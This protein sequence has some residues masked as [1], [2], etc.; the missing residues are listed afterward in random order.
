M[1][2]LTPMMKQYQE[3]KSETDGAILMFRLGDFYEM[4]GEDAELASKELEI[5]LTGRGAG[6]NRSPMCGV[7]YHSVDPYISKLISKGY[8]VAICEQMEDPSVAK[9]LVKRQITRIITPGTITDQ[10]MLVE[11]SNNYLMAVS[12]FA[13]RLGLAYVDAST[14]QFKALDI[15]SADQ[16]KSL[17][18]EIERISPSECLVGI[19]L[20]VEDPALVKFLE[21]RNIIVTKYSL[22]DIFDTD[23]A[24]E[25]L[26]RFFCVKSLEGFGFLGDEL[27]LCASSAVIDYLNETQKTSLGQINKIS[28]Y[29]I[30][31]FMSIDPSTRKNLELV[32]TIKD[33]A[34]KG[35]LLSILDR[36]ATPMGARKLRSWLLYPLKD[37]KEI[38]SRLDGVEELSKDP[39]LRQRLLLALSDIRDVERLSSRIAG[40]SANARDLVSLKESLLKLPDIKKLLSACSSFLLRKASTVSDMSDVVT[41]IA[42]AITDDPPFT[43]K[44]G[45]L[46]KTGY[47]A[48]LDEIKEASANG[49]KWISALEDSERRRTGI[50]SL[51]VGFTKVFGY[52]IEITSSNLKYAP[53]NYIRKQTLV[54]CERFIT[55]DLKDKEAMILNAEERLIETEYSVFCIVRDKAAEYIKE[56]QNIADLIATTDALLSLADTAVGENYCR[57]EFSASPMRIISGRHPVVE[58]TIGRHLFV[59]NDT[60]MDDNGSFIMLT[61]PNMAGKSTYMRQVALIVLLAQIGSFVPAKSATLPLVDRIFTRVGALDDLYAG[62]STFMVE[63]LE[64]SN[65]INNATSHSLIL[66][67][68]IGRG[69]ATFDGMSIACAV[70]EHIYEKIGAKTLF[71]THYHELTSLSDK[72]N[73]I[74]NMNISVK[75]EGDSIIFLHKIVDGPADKSYGI[76]VAKLAGLPKEVILRAKE[77]YN[78]LEMVENDFGKLGR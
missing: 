48:E 15:K 66:L 74:R 44:E 72:H 11:K 32:E 20:L 4:F 63:M 38:D 65:I 2:E 9:G 8:K 70:A 77:V 53:Q 25:K 28:P 56:L 27:S 39:V 7:P 22:K 46:I 31:S 78:T 36:T 18:D 58:N 47:S 1:A 49:K 10:S 76:Q 71:A 34:F 30:D 45:G 41:L 50:R 6:E 21:S 59:P 26:K 62:Q 69:T 51:K 24:Q 60:T 16:N 14:G 61:G 13:G 40:G 54:N 67:D 12:S 23:L 68:E 55:P 64:T 73:G 37:V 5:T 35:S 57:P 29:N 17:F 19:D 42:A 75:E 3:I 33:R 52:Y 43:V